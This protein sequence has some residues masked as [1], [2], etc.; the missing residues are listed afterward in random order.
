MGGRGS[1]TGGGGT[2]G[3][4]KG[5]IL[6][7]T[8]LLSQRET[9][10]RE[11]DEVMA[12]VKNVYDD[13]G[14]DLQD[15]QIATLK[16]G[17]RV[18]AYY[19][20]DGNLAVNKA[21]FDSAK[22]DAVYDI[23][24]D[25]KHHPSRGSKSGLEATAAHELGHRLTHKVA[26]D[27]WNRLDKEADSIVI[28]AKKKSGFKSVNDLR[29]SVSGYATKNNVEAIAEAF[30]DVYCNGDKA[31]RGSRAIVAELNARLGR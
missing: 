25:Q 18:M 19:D 15:I 26:G 8:S 22:M 16:P 3:I 7:T 21:Y 27:D 11:V 5:D 6:S 1:G 10:E 29:S 31:S 28:A 30:S 13:Y 4:K 14:L 17:V 23:C 12:A 9:Q 2:G 24:V 20:A